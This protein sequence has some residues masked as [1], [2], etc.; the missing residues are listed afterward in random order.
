MPA[1]YEL[2]CKTSRTFALAIPLLPE[3]T[4]STVCLSYLLFRVADTLEDAKA[5]P[6]A[7]R[8]EALAEWAKLL[9]TLDA[10]RARTAT[11]RW[12]ATPP[13]CNEAY[14]ELLDDVPH[15]LAEFSRLA[16]QTHRTVR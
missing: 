14:R 5:W 11:A 3:P 13:T 9:V 12:I 7:A 4:Q 1:L 16:P 10:A 2:L 8:L 6:R 15:V